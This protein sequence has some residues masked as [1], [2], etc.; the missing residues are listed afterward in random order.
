MDG[1]IKLEKTVNAYIGQH[2]ILGDAKKVVLAVSGGPD[3]L[4]LAHFMLTNY[5]ALTY[6]VAHL[7]HGLRPE[8]SEERRAIAAWA[9]RHNVA[10]V[11]Q[12]VDVAA[13]AADRKQGIEET[14]RQERYVFFRSLQPDLILTAHHGDDQAET[15]LSNILRGCGLAGLAGMAPREGDLGRPFLCVDKAAILAYCD[16]HGLVYHLDPSNEETSAYRRNRLRHELLPQM[17]NYN[18]RV[19]EALRR[20]ADTAREEDAFLA[21]ISATRYAA[22]VVHRGD[23]L[24]LPLTALHSEATAI[25]RRLVRLAVAASC[26]AEAD[27][28]L[29]GKILALSTGRKIYYDTIVVRNEGEAISFGPREERPLPTLA[30]KLRDGLDLILPEHGLRIQ[31]RQPAPGEERCLKNKCFIDSKDELILRYRRAGDRLALTAGGHKKLSDY[32]IDEKIPAHQR[33]YVPLL[34]RDQRVLWVVGYR[35]AADA[36]LAGDR[37]LVVDKWP[38]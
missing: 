35:F 8:S 10:F 4:A 14:G 2:Q 23:R 3:S 25:A 5:P 1:R 15:V 28:A 24:L 38:G 6:T 31:V 12:T 36:R 7:D 22:L 19:R 9:H 33:Q 26:G 18:P 20:L 16:R 21:A 27:F 32:F 34:C 13:L 29:T 17:T 11:A 37:L 30:I